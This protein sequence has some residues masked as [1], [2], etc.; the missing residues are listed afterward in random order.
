V[1]VGTGVGIGVGGG[2]GP[3][4]WGFGFMGAEPPLQ[5]ARSTAPTT[6]SGKLR[7]FMVNP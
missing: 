4:D 1:G 3:A 2:V 5:D 6:T 7:R